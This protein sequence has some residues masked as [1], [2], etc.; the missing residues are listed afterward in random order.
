MFE[1]SLVRDDSTCHNCNADGPRLSLTVVPK[2]VALGTVTPQ[3]MQKMNNFAAKCQA[4]YLPDAQSMAASRLDGGTAH[5]DLPPN[6]LGSGLST[7]QDGSL[8]LRATWLESTN[9][10]ALCA[11]VPLSHVQHSL[12]TGQQVKVDIPHNNGSFH[13]ST[14]GSGINAI[15]YQAA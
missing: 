4:H 15:Q 10:N 12:A 14:D 1:M 2:P 6:E 11:D 9:A 3:V 7:L 5:A 13:F 8:A